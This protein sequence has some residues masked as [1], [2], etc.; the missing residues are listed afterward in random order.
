MTP[1]GPD[2]IAVLLESLTRGNEAAFEPL[3]LADPPD[4]L[5]HTPFIH[6]LARTAAPLRA[7]E[8]G[9]DSGNSYC[10]LAQS[11]AELGLK[12][13]CLGVAPWPGDAPREEPST[14]ADLAAHHDPLYGHFSRLVRSTFDQALSL[15][16]DGSVDMLHIDARPAV[17]TVRHD[18]ETWRPKLSSSGVALLSGVYETRNGFCVDQYWEGLRATFPGFVFPHGHGLGVLL[19]GKGP[20]TAL[21]GLAALDRTPKG[22]WVRAH[23]ARLGQGVVQTYELRRR[24]NAMDALREERDALTHSLRRE[25]ELRMELTRSLDQAKTT[26]LALRA[27]VNVLREALERSDRLGEERLEILD[28]ARTQIRQLR[29]EGIRLGFQA[30]ACRNS[31]SWKITAPLRRLGAALRR[32]PHREAQEREARTIRESGLFDQAFYLEQNPDVAA[33]G[34]DPA[35]HYVVHGWREGRRV[36]S[37]F[38]QDFYLKHHPEAQNSGLSPLAYYLAHDKTSGHDPNPLFDTAFYLG[39]SPDVAEADSNPLVHYLDHGAGEGRDPHADFVTRFVLLNNPELARSGE[40]PLA[41]HLRTG[42][43]APTAPSPDRLAQLSRPTPAALDW[44]RDMGRTLRPRIAFAVFL[45]ARGQRLPLAMEAA[46]SLLAQTYPFWRLVLLAD[47]NDTAP[48][49][50]LL[51]RDPRVD[52]RRDDFSTRMGAACLDQVAEDARGAGPSGPPLNV[53]AWAVHLTCTRRLEP[54]ALFEMARAVA[55]RRSL[56]LLTADDLVPDSCGRFRPRL[57]YGL[58]PLPSAMTVPRDELVALSGETFKRSGEP[59]QLDEERGVRALFDGLALTTDQAVNLPLLLSRTMGNACLDAAPVKPDPP[60]A[61]A[62]SVS[63]PAFP[64]ASVIIPTAGKHI[65]E[66]LVPCLA[67]L[68]A[69]PA[70]LAFEV[71]LVDNSPEGLSLNDLVRPLPAEIKISLVRDDGPFNFPRLIN[72]GAKASRG[73]LLVLLN[74]DVEVLNDGW[75]TALA[76]L[77]AIP[78]CAV[79]GAKLLYPNGRIQHAGMFHTRKGF[80]H[81]FLRTRDDGALNPLLAQARRVTAV[82]F[83]CAAVPRTV[84]DRLGGLNPSYAV[85]CNDTD[86]C[87]RAAQAGLFAAWTPKAVLRHKESASRRGIPVSADRA[88]LLEAWAESLSAQD[89]YSHQHLSPCA[90]LPRSTCVPVFVERHVPSLTAEDAACLGL[91]AGPGAA[92]PQTILAMELGHLGDLVLALPALTALRR[93]FPDARLTLV[94]SPA[95]L[96]LALRLCDVDEVVAQ[97]LFHP[98]SEEGLLPGRGPRLVE[99]LTGR[100][101]DLAVDLRRHPESRPLLDGIQANLRAG[102]APDA[103]GPNG[104]GPTGNICLPLIDRV[105][106][107]AGYVDKLHAAA[108][109]FALAVA[110]APPQRRSGLV[111]NECLPRLVSRLDRRV[112]LERFNLP[113]GRPLV[114]LHPGSGSSMRR[115]PISFWAELADRLIRDKTAHILLLGASD[116]AQLAGQVLAVCS[117]PDSV[118]TLAGQLCLND[119]CDLLP[120]LDGFVGNNSGPC[121][122]AGI[123]GVATVTPWSG[124]VS[125]REWLAMGPRTLCVWAA[126]PCAPCYRSLLEHCP[127]NRLCLQRVSPAAVFDALNGLLAFENPK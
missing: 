54:Q 1:V 8:L 39:H 115:W 76:D 49:P 16:A 67:S 78:G 38:D 85:E 77:A 51:D 30:E 103:N 65:T 27:Q 53:V 110:C 84:W 4:R 52:V 70:G 89:S 105:A 9:V 66:N 62:V 116:E 22:D 43:S 88:R 64:L 94:C 93:T 57:K 99:E 69:R 79:V 83:A 47:A 117:R 28:L 26:E 40:N 112:V 122:L 56:L 20:P 11:V 86:F 87:L 81:V 68:A 17:D 101:F 96:D 80:R 72:A 59:F 10:A 92:N 95:N 107:L 127:F 63:E 60:V 124:Q 58:P 14:L 114:G 46:E 109:K 32:E 111:L 3:R 25:R 73:D 2:A 50:I 108:Q 5:E 106:D 71:V 6:W 123:A 31:L 61:A 75:L 55:T 100:R 35:L 19:V 119:F 97:P 12:T 126:T 82:T 23:F 120:H 21:A 33:T 48:L 36:S 113:A 98:R 118:T 41:W 125:P 34:H 91:T 42:R 104:S 29:T 90:P 15:A 13:T 44:Q 74:D 24:E 37:V 121:H 45:D 18:F 7:V 102:Y